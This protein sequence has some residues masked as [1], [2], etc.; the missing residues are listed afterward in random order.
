MYGEWL[1]QY[2]IS[3]ALIAALLSYV[4]LKRFK[5]RKALAKKGVQNPA[6]LMEKLPIGLAVLNAEGKILEAN[7]YFSNIFNRK[8]VRGL[9]IEKIFPNTSFHLHIALRHSIE[10]LNSGE[11]V[12]YIKLSQ[13]KREDENR[14]IIC[15]DITTQMQNLRKQQDIQPAL[16]LMQ[17]DNLFEVLQT[18]TDEAKPHVFAALDKELGEWAATMEAYLRPIGEG[19]YIL[20]F[21]DWGYQQ[22]EKTR[23]AI[24]DKIREIDFGNDIPLTISIGVGIR[25]ENI[26]EL[27][28][29]AQSALDIA[30]ERGGDQAVVRTPE[31]IRYYGGKSIGVE[32]RTKVKARVT[33][34]ALKEM[35]VHAAQVI[36][37]GHEMADYDSIGAS[38]GMAKVASDL[39]KKALVVVD[40]YNPGTDQLFDALPQGSLCVGLIKPGELGRKPLDNTLLIIVDTHKPSLLPYP[41]LLQQASQV[42]VID[43]H[44]RGEEFIQEARLVYLESYASSASELVTEMIQY[45][46]DQVEISKAEATA[47]L[48]GITVDT[49]N[50]MLQTGVR[51]FAAAAYLRSRGADPTLVRKLLSDNIATVVKKAEVLRN[52]RV[53]YGKIA[54]GICREIS[55]DAQLMA[56]KTADTMLNIA[57][58]SASI[59]VWPFDNGIAVSARSNGEINVQAIMEEMGGGGHLTVAAAQINDTLQRVEARLLEILEDKFQTKR[60]GL[61]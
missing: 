42:A 41:S 34:D 56:A 14:Y 1:W 33:A 6:E 59:V 35:I 32:K 9:G 38:L 23:F 30:L 39:G 44:R 27:G 13:A 46:G 25:E 29:M 52:A 21:T 45:L 28:R 36:V 2:L 60:E 7:S 55:H 4:G 51:T 10:I 20:F 37:M 48:A 26:N 31:S 3:A 54:L 12:L 53:L 50:F 24:L 43:H 40:N 61:V 19:R 18:I 47:L 16:A 11:K 8:N 17:I 58:V 57:G 49:K 15:E 5:H 22:A